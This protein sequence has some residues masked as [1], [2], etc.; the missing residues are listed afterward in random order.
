[1]QCSEEGHRG[2]VNVFLCLAQPPNQQSYRA[3][4]DPKDCSYLTGFLYV[5]VPLQ[6]SSQLPF[7]VSAMAHLGTLN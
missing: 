5:D 1:M 6:I 3:E 4:D 7:Q 2:W